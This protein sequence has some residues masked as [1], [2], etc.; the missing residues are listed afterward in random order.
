[1]MVPRA[2][3]D[4]CRPPCRARSLAVAAAAEL[5]EIDALASKIGI[6]GARY[7]ERLNK[8]VNR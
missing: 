4:A 5:R 8:L 3:R 2:S 6:E 7:P 1:M